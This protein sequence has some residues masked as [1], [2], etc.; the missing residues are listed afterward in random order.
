MGSSL[1]WRKF[2]CAADFLVLPPLS[3]RNLLWIVISKFGNNNLSLT[4]PKFKENLATFYQ[5]LLVFNR[6]LWKLSSN[7]WLLLLL[8]SYFWFNCIFQQFPIVRI[9][10]KALIR[11]LVNFLS[12]NYRSHFSDNWPQQLY[13]Y[14]LITQ[15]ALQSCLSAT[16]DNGTHIAE[17]LLSSSFFHYIKAISPFPIMNTCMHLTQLCAR[18][19][20]W[21]P[22]N[23]ARSEFLACSAGRL[24]VMIYCSSKWPKHSKAQ[25]D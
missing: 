25:W 13:V 7:F 4:Q 18:E 9:G 24:Y 10:N 20:V 12:C 14:L 22:P 23:A 19:I 16:I 21:L 2:N 17:V 3:S 15:E 1:K 6:S 11:V 5:A 8:L